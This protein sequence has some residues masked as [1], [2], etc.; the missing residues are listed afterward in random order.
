MERV[1]RRRSERRAEELSRCSNWTWGCAGKS[2]E[3]CVKGESDRYAEQLRVDLLSTAAVVVVVVVVVVVGFEA[4]DHPTPV[5]LATALWY[6]AISCYP[7]TT[8]L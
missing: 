1:G 4:R 2:G 7:T 5:T 8:S 6:A 3:V